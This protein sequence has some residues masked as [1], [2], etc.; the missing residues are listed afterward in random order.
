M[1]YSEHKNCISLPAV[2]ALLASDPLAVI[3]AAEE[4]YHA[5]IDA[6]ASACL[7][8]DCDVILLCGPSAAGKTTTSDRLLRRL[9]AAGKRVARISLDDFYLPNS[10]MPYWEDGTIN[11]ESIDC[12]DIALFSRLCKTLHTEGRAEFPVFDF[13]TGGNAE[14]FVIEHRAGDVLIVEGLHALN[15][16]VAAAFSENRCLRVYISTHSD[17]CADGEVV[18][19][20]KLLRLARRMLRDV[21]HRNTDANETVGMWRYIRMG[22][23]RYIHP[24]RETADFKIDTAHAYEP[25]LYGYQLAEALKNHPL[26]EE[27]AEIAAVF[28]R[29]YDLPPIAEERIPKDSLIQE[30]IG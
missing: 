23:E 17:F 13:K 12:L 6:V 9:A 14:P 18:L 24:H 21:T 28:A 7:K 3:G 16:L 22:E 11:F 15:P 27:Y 8:R 2:A 26:G 5:N 20:A 19:P 4:N 1:H 25:F 30:F 29:L 10:K